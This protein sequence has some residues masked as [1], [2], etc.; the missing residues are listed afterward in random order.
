MISELT[1]EL[2]HHLLD[3]TVELDAG[4][5]MAA[6]RGLI[7]YFAVSLQAHA[8]PEI[9]P[10]LRWIEQEGGSPDAWLLGYS[11]QVTARQ[12]ALFNGMQAH[13][14][15]YDDVHADVRG[16]P[17]AVILPALFS[18][19]TPDDSGLDLLRA[20]VQ[21]VELMAR[22]GR[23]VHPYHYERGWHNT[24]T[25]GVLA[26]T[27]ALCVL[28]H[29][30]ATETTQALTLAVTQ[31]SGLRL[32]FGTPVKP[33]HAGLAAQAA[34]QSVVWVRAGLI[35]NSNPDP[36]KDPFDPERGFL[37]VYGDTCVHVE[38]SGE[39]AVRTQSSLVAEW[40]H[41]WRISQPGLWFKT[42][43][44]CS[45]AAHLIDAAQ[46]LYQRHLW[47]LEDLAQV[48]IQFATNTDKA[49]IYKTPITG[50]QGRF[51]A[52]YIVLRA[53]TGQPLDFTAFAAETRIP[54]AMQD[55]FDRV[56]RTYPAAGDLLPDGLSYPAGRFA[57]VTVTTTSGLTDTALCTVPWGCPLKPYPTSAL[58]QKLIHASSP[59]YAK[60][61]VD[62]IDRLPESTLQTLFR[63]GISPKPYRSL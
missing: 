24:A 28:R 45:A 7:D 25:L 26:A 59:E 23:A 29:L 5:V 37:A 53:L 6:Q 56:S 4:T 8:A 51:S 47:E 43:P 42:N 3:D 52:E 22:L 54:L 44:C 55:A 49:L 18:L 34:V 10:L 27:A 40:G 21:G 17:S 32:M 19:A 14:L 1:R 30:S 13:L 11:R 41:S 33:L 38:D 9:Q 35:A 61:L 39:L 36:D 16:H 63:V 62:A 50:E 20:Y 15:D 60:T 2:V 57:R 46:E 48:T 58:V 31:A 12:A